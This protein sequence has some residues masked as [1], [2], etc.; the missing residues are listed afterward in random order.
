MKFL[1]KVQKAHASKTA[2]IVRV[3]CFSLFLFIYA[4]T[5]IRNN[6]FS[7][8]FTVAIAAILIALCICLKKV[9]STDKKYYEDERAGILGFV[10]DYGI[11]LSALG[12]IVILYYGIFYGIDLSQSH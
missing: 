11:I 3:V 6:F 8:I 9:I 7:G 12:K 10:I 2:V 1:E 5:T 4:I